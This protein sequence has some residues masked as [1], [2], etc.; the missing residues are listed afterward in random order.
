MQAIRW[1][2]FSALMALLLLSGRAT[3]PA[4]EKAA[5]GKVTFEVARYDRLGEVVRQEKGK[6][7]VVSFWSTT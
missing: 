1:W 5:D 2:G 6:V 7:V 4:Q 3:A